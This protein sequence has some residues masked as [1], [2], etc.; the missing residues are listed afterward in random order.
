[1]T[2]NDQE[3]IIGSVYRH[4]GGNIQHFID[5][6]SHILKQAN[7]K[8]FYVWAGDINIDT[9]KYDKD[10]NISDYVTNFIEA[11][12][13]P[14]ITLPTRFTDVSATLI[15]H[16]MVKVPQKIIQNKV[17]AGNLVTDITDP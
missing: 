11:N 1:M 3:F 16:I 17:S 2:S 13:I 14:C 5:A 6:F 9:L 8:A 15:D 4:P 7:D 12:F 10:K